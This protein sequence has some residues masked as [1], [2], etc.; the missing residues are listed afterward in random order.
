MAARDSYDWSVFGLVGDPVPGDPGAV[1]NVGQMIT[2][3]ETAAY[4]VRVGVNGLVTDPAVNAWLGASGD[5][6]RA[7]LGPV[8]GLLQQMVDAYNEA[9]AAVF[10]YGSDLAA[11][12][13]IADS[14]YQQR[15]NTLND[16]KSNNPGKTPPADGSVPDGVPPLLWNLQTGGIDNACSS[17]D[18]AANACATALGDAVDALHRVVRALNDPKFKDFN[19]T[20]VA[21]GGDLSVLTRPPARGLGDVIENAQVTDLNHILAGGQTDA[22]PDVVRAELNDLTSEYQ[23]DRTFWQQFAP[24][25]GTLVPWIQNN[26]GPDRTDAADQQLIATLGSR[27][28]TAASNGSL[29]SRDV[30]GFGTAGLI[31]LSQLIGTTKGSDYQNETGLQFLDDVDRTFIDQESGVG[32]DD[33]ASFDGAM[34]TGL[35]VTAQNDAAARDLFAGP[36][37]KD[38]A[39]KL[40]QGSALV[41]TQDAPD[42]GGSSSSTDSA[43]DGVDPR[44][45]AAL[46]DAARAPVDRWS[47]VRGNSP[48]DLARIQAAMNIVGAAA[49]MDH[50]SPPG[51]SASWGL[52]PQ[53]TDAL[54][55]YAK[56]YS[57]DLGM[58]TTDGN[59]GAGVTTVDGRPGGPPVFM[60]TSQ[61]AQDFLDLAL[62]DPHA[63]GDYLGFAKA[64]FQDSVKLDMMSNGVVDHTSGYANLVAT[65]QQIIDGQHLSDAQAQDAAA[66]QKAALVSALL[67]GFGNGPGPDSVGIGQA[68]DGLLTP[69][70][71]Q[72]PGLATDHTAEAQV[73]IHQADQL[74]GRQADLTVVQAAVDSGLLKTGPGPDDIPPGI[75]DSSGHVQ[76]SAQFRNWFNGGGKNIIVAPTGDP[77]RQGLSLE[78][79]V[80]RMTD[81]MNGHS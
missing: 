59:S 49:E 23:D 76:D 67:G 71:D 1:Q 18:Q 22:S 65:T 66:A 36:D 73:A 4:E 74:I 11:A 30:T 50:W 52:P 9:A 64:Q 40:M 72:L 28:A 58:S 3:R 62:K 34:N 21:N 56:A 48:D 77:H 20:Y 12:Q 70:L 47:D 43:Y 19:S 44:T 37:G 57:F 26:K 68:L 15:L 51:Q 8:P 33:H 10:K 42:R 27:M 13:Q 69:Y 6:F 17:R 55:G 14:T 41:T 16:W 38:L 80:K 78:N 53:V 7:T 29:I 25:L 35:A 79:Y 5:A 81:A 75:V 63:A 31:G 24:S 54:E 60:V 46:L 2:A 39:E 61:Q 32:Y 45:I